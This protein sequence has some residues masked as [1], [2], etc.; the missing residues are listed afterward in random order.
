[1]ARLLVASCL[2][3]ILFPLVIWRAGELLMAA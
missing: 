2:Y 1:M 3:A